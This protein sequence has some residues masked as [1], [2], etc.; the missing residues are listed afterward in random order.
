MV[1][2]HK[3]YVNDKSEQLFKV[4]EWTLKADLLERKCL[5]RSQEVNESKEKMLFKKNAQ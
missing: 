1:K 4:A 2:T 5:V 3:W